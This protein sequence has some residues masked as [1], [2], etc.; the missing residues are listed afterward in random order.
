MKCG[1]RYQSSKTDKGEKKISLKTE[2][3]KRF[4]F[5]QWLFSPQTQMLEFTWVQN[6][7]C[8]VNVGSAAKNVKWLFSRNPQ[9][10]QGGKPFLL[11]VWKKK[12]K[13]KE[14]GRFHPESKNYL[15]SH[16]NLSEPAD[17]GGFVLWASGLAMPLLPPSQVRA[18][19]LSFA[20]RNSPSCR[21]VAQKS[22]S[23]SFRTKQLAGWDR[24][25]CCLARQVFPLLSCPW[26]C[27]AQ[28]PVVCWPFSGPA[29]SIAAAC[30]LMLP[31]ELLGSLLCTAELCSL[32]GGHRTTLHKLS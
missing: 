5:Q 2:N 13:Q 7:C 15:F 11:R 10:C 19:G 24:Q 29:P 26:L 20:R 21:S 30:C 23:L 14:N 4:S 9:H 31:R 1:K 32:G 27:K 22:T 3:V 28:D 17:S 25:E 6:P 16:V 12:P 18:Q 8:H